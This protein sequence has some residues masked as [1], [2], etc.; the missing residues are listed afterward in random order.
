MSHRS[1]NSYVCFSCIFRAVLI[2]LLSVLI[3]LMQYGTCIIQPK[4]IPCAT[5][6]L[7]EM[8]KFGNL[9]RLWQFATFFSIHLKAARK[10]P[11]LLSLLV[12]LEEVTTCGM[13]LS[14]EDEA[15]AYQSGIKLKVRAFSKFQLTSH[16][17]S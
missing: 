17:S 1:D 5:E 12:S 8:I 2:L 10:D 16:S 15:F 6:E 4:R 9:N 3:S 13:A 14:Q 7:I 11:E